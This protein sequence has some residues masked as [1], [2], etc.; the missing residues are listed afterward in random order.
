MSEL[1]R[2]QSAVEAVET[3]APV[4]PRPV[5]RAQIVAAAAS[6]FRQ[7]GYGGATLND[8]AD[9]VGIHK[10]SLYHHITSKQEL[11]MNIL[12]SG[13]ARSTPALETIVADPSLASCERLDRAVRMHVGEVFSTQDI[14]AVFVRGFGDVTD[15]DRR[16]AYL[17]KR[18][19]YEAT[20]GSIIEECVVAHDHP[21]D[22][23]LLRLLLLGMC[24][25]IATWYS[26]AGS[27][28]EQEIV[29]Q[30]ARVAARMVGCERAQG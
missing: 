18:R 13:L 16:E 2:A 29:E 14:I 8:I 6:V 21:D 23:H 20:F 4:R 9:V 22:P 26:P 3:G 24:N 10:A 25:S 27:N 11:L 12:D 1:T 17:G 28:S 7:R 15:A 19:R 30:A 5:T